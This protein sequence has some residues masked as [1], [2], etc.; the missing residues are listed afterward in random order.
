MDNDQGQFIK[1][2]FDPYFEAPLDLWNAFASH[3]TK[4]T[5]KKNEILKEENK[6]EKYIN[7][8][9]T[10]SVGVFLW[11]DNNTKCLDLFYD[12][13]FCCDYMSFLEQKPSLLF[14]QALEKTD[15]YSISHSDVSNLYFESVVGPQIV[16]A[17]A[18]SLF[19]HKQRQQIEL[20][21]LSAEERYKKL[22][23][24]EPE[25]IQRTAAKDI[26]SYLGIAPE[27]ISRIRKKMA[28][29]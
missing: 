17:A 5:F 27:S 7:I 11:A 22:L 10:G 13:Y 25:I 18:Q 29:D 9:I 23:T 26:A 4:R 8:I 12:Q 6:T 24:E 28:I 20:M 21:T 19:I 15:V 2:L 3:L 14:T 16:K 1:Q